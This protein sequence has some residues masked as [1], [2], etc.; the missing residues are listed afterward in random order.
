[1]PSADRRLQPR[2]KPSQVRAELTRERILT[3][4]AHVFTE[5]GYAAG[6]TNRIAER[7]RISIGSLYQY[8]PNK[9]AILAELAVRH[10]DRGTWTRADQ[11]DLSAGSLEAAVRTLVR[12]AVD[13]HRD[14]PRLLRI[15][16]E[17]VPLSRE[18][19]DTIDRHEK[20]RVGQ[21]RDLLAR[22]PDVRVRDLD[23]AADLIVTTV[24][25]NTH[26]IMARPQTTSVETFENELV[27]MVTRYLRGDQ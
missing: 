13:N 27:D 8:F 24:E 4:A 20:T 7:A 25:L 11:F 21:V 5:Y 9:D 16:I 22:H 18:L 6:T 15:M 2:R 10:L 1:M 14:D 3:A 26:K 19:L 17:E 23:T 12:D